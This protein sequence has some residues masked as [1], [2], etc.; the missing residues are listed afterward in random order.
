MNFYWL[1]NLSNLQFFAIVVSTFVLFSIIGNYIFNNY[2]N[3]KLSLSE[4]TNGIIGIFLSLSGVFYGITLGLIA[5][6]TF[7]TFSSTGGIVTNES[8]SLG[9]LYKNVSLLKDK[10]NIKLKNILKEYT[11]YVVNQAWP[12]QQRGEV[13]R[14]GSKI[15]EKFQN[16]LAVYQIVDNKDEVI[17]GEVMSQ[18]GQ[19]LQYRNQRLNSI[20]NSLPVTVWWILIVGAV[21]NLMFIWLVQVQNKRFEFIL[22][23]LV[24]MLVG[25]L[26]FLIAAMDNPYR[27]EY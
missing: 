27:G 9:S 10:D 3:V 26:I 19:L 20:T 1:Y 8:S 6:G 2:I 14:G 25:S 17:F 7:E 18:F 15:M 24:S 22:N 5:A 12:M 21:I 4:E 16:Q 23:V 11:E 13:P